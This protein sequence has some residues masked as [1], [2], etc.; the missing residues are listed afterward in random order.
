M[1]HAFDLSRHEKL[2][3]EKIM[4]QGNIEFYVYMHPLIVVSNAYQLLYNVQTFKEMT[5]VRKLLIC[6]G[7]HEIDVL[8]AMT[9]KAPPHVWPF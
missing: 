4:R 5:A 1:I 9:L 8:T 7:E 2:R 6:L 3:I